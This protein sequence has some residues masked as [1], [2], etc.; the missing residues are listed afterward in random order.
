MRLHDAAGVL[1]AVR[2]MVV[3]RLLPIVMGDEVLD[4]CQRVLHAA[5]KD[6]QR[7]KGTALLREFCGLLRCVHAA[8]ALQGRGRQ[9]LTAQRR[10][11]LLHVDFVTVLA[12]DVD[13]VERD[14]HRNAQLG[15]LRGQVEVALDVRRIH[16]VED[17]VGLL[18]DQIAARDDL[19]QRVGREGVNARQVLDDDILR[20]AQPA[21]L[22]FDR[23]A[24][25]VAH[26]LVAAGEVVEHGGLAAVRVARQGN[27]D[28]HSF[29][30]LVLG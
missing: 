8:L 5:V 10:A 4:V 13:H 14:D 25:P 26:I 12:R 16:D 9:D 2:V 24:R 27:L 21:F 7:L 11:E 18:A 30:S 6:V 28:G 19:L 1:G 3:L 17:R 15:E 20:A 29:A 23:D 22:L